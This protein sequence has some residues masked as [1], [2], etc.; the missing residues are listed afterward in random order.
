MHILPSETLRIVRDVA[1][2]RV[3]FKWCFRYYLLCEAPSYKARNIEQLL[4][5]PYDESAA[6]VV[7]P[8]VGRGQ[9]RDKGLRRWLSRATLHKNEEPTERL[10]DVLGYLNLPCPEKGQ[11]ALRMWGQTGDRPTVW[12]AAA[13]PVYLEPRLD[14]VLLHALNAVQAGRSDLRPLFDHLQRELQGDAGIGF[15]RIGTCGYVRANQAIAT[16]SEPAYV[17]N[18]QTPNEYMPSGDDT[19]SYRNLRSEIE[20]AL[21][22]HEVNLRREGRGELPVN[23]LWIWGGGFAPEQETISL[24]PL[25]T[26]DPL[27]KGHWFS[28]TGFAGSWPGTIAKCIE[29]SEAG[30]VAVT[31]DDGD[32]DML[33]RCLHELREAMRSGRLRKLTLMF[34]DGVRADMRRSHFLRVWRRTSAVLN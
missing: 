6:V 14:R 31:P 3:N 30:F 16:A 10:A 28:K 33:E 22:D 9:L 5:T 1:V 27:L 26:N 18:L 12:I 24:P 17:L 29:S 8:A 4:T 15:A 11:G 20:M 19:G 2:S 25:F 13:D 32:G 23:S 34:R 7:L 21:H